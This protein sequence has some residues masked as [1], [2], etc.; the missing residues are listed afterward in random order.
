[1]PDIRKI[2]PSIH[3]AQIATV[4]VNPETHLELIEYV[5]GRVVRGVS[6]VCHEQKT[7]PDNDRMTKPLHSRHNRY[8][9]WLNFRHNTCS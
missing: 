1:M 4:E 2:T 5:A 3:F 9:E 8:V 7:S 6:A